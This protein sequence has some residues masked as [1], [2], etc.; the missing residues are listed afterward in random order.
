MADVSRP[1]GLPPSQ[2]VGCAS[3]VGFDCE[4]RALVVAELLKDNASIT[5]PRRTMTYTTRARFL[6]PAGGAIVAKKEGSA[7]TVWPAADRN[8]SRNVLVPDF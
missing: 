1:D 4:L 7:L 2:V 5:A 3:A 6:L 8:A